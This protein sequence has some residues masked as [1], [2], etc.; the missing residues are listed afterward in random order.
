MT[1]GIKKQAAATRHQ[2]QPVSRE[3]QEALEA[4]WIDWDGI[5]QRSAAFEFSIQRLLDAA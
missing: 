2:P 5:R 3:F 1:H 4:E